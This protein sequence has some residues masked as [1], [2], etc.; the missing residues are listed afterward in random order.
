MDKL[1]Q[2]LSTLENDY[3]K[4]WAKTL[5]E[6]LD[7]QRV[8]SRDSIVACSLYLFQASINEKYDSEIKKYE[9]EI[10]ELKEQVRLQLE[11][12]RLKNEELQRVGPPPIMGIQY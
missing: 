4:D 8:S 10:H 11:Q 6:E 3:K 5:Q 2:K 9:D 12:Q 1:K 7:K